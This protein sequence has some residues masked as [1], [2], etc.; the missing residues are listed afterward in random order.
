MKRRGSNVWA[1][2]G[3]HDRHFYR[4]LLSPLILFLFP[5]FRFPSSSGFR[6]LPFIP[7]SDS[8]LLTS[9]S[10]LLTSDSWLLTSDSWLLTS[11]S[12]L[13]TSDSWLL[14]SGSWLPG[15]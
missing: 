2:F 13:L 3:N 5:F 6:P 12:W 7:S 4:R 9:G 1:Q 11:G 10:W 15:R 14:T 8:W